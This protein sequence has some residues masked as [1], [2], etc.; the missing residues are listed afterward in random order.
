VGGGR[1]NHGFKKL[2]GMCKDALGQVMGHSVLK[3]G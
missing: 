2:M 3:A 1:Y